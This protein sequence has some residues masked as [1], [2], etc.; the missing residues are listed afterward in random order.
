MYNLGT[1]PGIGRVIEYEVPLKEKNESTHGDIDLLCTSDDSVLCVEA[2][3]PGSDD[4][5]IKAV[6][7]AFVYTSLV[8][9]C[10][11]RFLSD[12]GL[13]G[14]MT[15]TPVVITFASSRSGEQL[16]KRDK[17]PQLQRLLAFVNEALQERKIAPMQFFVVEDR[18]ISM[19]KCLILTTDENGL[20][21]PV[22]RSGFPWR[23]IRHTL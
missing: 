15:M 16:R 23:V 12:F 3:A 6:L 22:F 9:T 14:N 20:K 5:L 17:H 1:L 4:T 19:D 8:A 2:K 11:T 7:Q 18:T 21:K 13:P 10:R